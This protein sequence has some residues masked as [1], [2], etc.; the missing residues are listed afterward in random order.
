MI[1]YKVPL[2]YAFFYGL[3]VA[4]LSGMF[5]FLPWSM[6]LEYQLYDRIQQKTVIDSK[7]DWQY[8][9]YAPWLEQVTLINLDSSFIDK[10]TDRIKANKLAKF[11]EKI[12]TQ[13][14][15]SKIIFL[16]YEYNASI[17]KERTLF[18]AL[19]K[20]QQRLI[21]P[22]GI[23]INKKIAIRGKNSQ[24]TKVDIK[25][26][27]YDQVPALAYGYTS[28][29]TDPY[30]FSNRYYKYRTDDTSYCSVPYLIQKQIS[31]QPEKNLYQ[32][33][34]TELKFVLRN[35][36]V[37]NKERAILV[38]D[39]RYILDGRMDKENVKSV[40]EDKIVFIGLFD[41]Y[42]T[43]HGLSVDK[44]LTPVQSNMS[45]S[46]LLVN[47]WLNLAAGGLV[48]VNP[49]LLIFLFNFIVALIMSTWYQSTRGK[50][51]SAMITLF[52]NLGISL[53]L[54][55]MVGLLLFLVLEVKLALGVSLLLFQYH[56]Q[57]FVYIN[58]KTKYISD[59]KNN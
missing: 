34:L 48:R 45:G 33:G 9:Y 47:A 38:Y 25:L 49:V 22:L 40:I 51:W 55:P 14:L 2:I 53:I 4:I 52:I 36:D 10:E 15:N 11:I 58:E 16:D 56:Y 1:K 13:L 27:K 42:R 24:L 18:N 41:N 43:K 12:D 19:S 50:E 35:E 21:L 23:D 3:L 39:A 37:L 5:F 7:G 44:F 31:N 54:F 28:P 20:I 8:N 29:F 57:I 46:M 17:D 26:K 59:A 30:S 6:S 32:K